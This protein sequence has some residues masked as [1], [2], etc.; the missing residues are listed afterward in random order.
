[1][2]LFI[3]NNTDGNFYFKPD[4][5]LCNN[6]DD[7]YYPDYINDLIIQPGFAVRI[8]KSGK[9]INAKFSERYYNQIDFAANIIHSSL[10]KKHIVLEELT[11]F[12]SLE[13]SL[14]HIDI[15]MDLTEN[16]GNECILLSNGINTVKLNLDSN[17]KNKINLAI[18]KISRVFI[19]KSGDLVVLVDNV[20]LDINK[21][22]LITLFKSN[23]RE[24][25]TKLLDFS[26]K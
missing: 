26:I 18:E 6:N 25:Y 10:L 2:N 24:D 3:L 11:H 22:N 16:Y 20:Y 15:N 8:T 19:L 4:T 13:K 7:F 23:M 17:I 21:G 12:S 14:Y 5:C 9:G 1:M